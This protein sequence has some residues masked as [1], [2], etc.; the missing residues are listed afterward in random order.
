MDLPKK[1]PVRTIK[2]LS[3][4]QLK[5]MI[6]YFDNTL[7]RATAFHSL[8]AVSPN[9][10]MRKLGKEFI[11]DYKAAKKF[12]PIVQKEILRRD[13]GKA[14]PDES[15]SPKPKK[16]VKKKAGQRVGVSSTKSVK[17]AKKATDEEK[18]RRYKQFRNNNPST[19]PSV[20]NTG[21]KVGIKEVPIIKVGPK[22]GKHKGKV[23]GTGKIK[24]SHNRLY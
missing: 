14:M 10:E 3:D 19:K 2:N 18:K 6:K 12:K 17:A 24:V 8:A 4:S 15:V 20:M 21:G 1:S 9:P 11:E 5:K 16:A 22:G 23:V 7:S 13:K